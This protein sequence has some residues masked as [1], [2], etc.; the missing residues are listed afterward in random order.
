LADETPILPAHI[1]DTIRAIA[2]L[3]VDHHLEAGGL[4]R[5]VDRLTAWIARPA[6]IALLT[7]AVAAWVGG[8]LLVSLLGAIAWDPP[9]FNWLQGGV[10]LLALM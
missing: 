2:K 9:P 7:V 1:E 5:L 8:N 4:Q 3:H 10:T 6:F